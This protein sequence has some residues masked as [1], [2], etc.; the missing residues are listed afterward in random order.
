V[1][2]GRATL[3]GTSRFARRSK[4]AEGH[5][6]TAAGVLVSS[7]GL[8]TYLGGEDAATDAGYE[9]CV[10]IALTGGINVFD[11]AIN[12]RGQRSERAIGRALSRAIREGGA[13]RDEIFV[14]TK[15][16]YLPHDAEDP[17]DPRRY[18]LETFVESGLA[19]RSEIA[20]GGNCLAPA[21]LRDQIDRSRENLGLETIDLY[22]LHNIEAQ[23]TS[24]DF[25]TF[26]KRLSLAAEVLEE[27]A[28]EE[29]IGS[30]GLATWDGLR[31]PPEHPEHLSM[32][33]ALE[34]ATQ[35]AGR[36]H[37]FTAVQMPLNLAM[38]QAIAY[39]SQETEGGRV[40]ALSAAATL[41]LAV[42]GSASLLQGRLSADL[43]E[44]IVEAFSEALS[45]SQ[46]ALQFSRSAPGMTTS[47]VGV[48]DPAHARDNFAL[49]AVGPADPARVLALFR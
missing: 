19:P 24:V 9:A 14:S 22:Y 15:G 25:A 34:I 45:G 2:A 41:G 48:S 36:A 43:P 38:A 35:A 46:R 28:S 42:F 21:Y 12:Y 40:S 1:I 11:S 7:I 44:E 30:W 4:A 31:V 8:G 10:A 20:A 18:I 26:R 29:K 5:F 37:H 49:A 16:G 6:R 39:S 3:E 33:A 23:R 47:L 17:R 27:A 32:K 13:A